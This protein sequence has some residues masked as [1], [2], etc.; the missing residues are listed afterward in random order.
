MSEQLRLDDA[1]LPDYLRRLGLVAAGTPVEVEAAGDGNI[2]WVRRA[3]CPGHSWIVKQA[4]PALERF[5]EYRVPTERIVFEARY[6]EAVRAVDDGCVCP[7]VLHFDARERVLI[8]EDLSGSERLDAALVRGFDASGAAARLGRFLGRVHA[9][10]DRG[11]L[12]P[13][14]ENDA[15][16]RLHGDHI[17]ELPLRKNDFPLSPRLRAAAD[18]LA[19]DRALI[20]L[21][22]AA[23]ARYLEPRG[24]L[25]HGDV[26]AGNVLLAA[27]GAKLLDA[28]IA[29]IGDPCFDVGTLVAHLLLPAAAAG[30]A[31]PAVRY[32][33]A[34]WSA[35]ATT[36]TRLARGA[37]R[38]VARYAGLEMLRRT[39]GAARVPAVE[40]D[41]AG[42]A[43][44]ETALHLI[45]TPPESPDG[46]AV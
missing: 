40:R 32:A 33:E 12:A 2:N 45:R 9:A 46:I 36:R 44:L 25:V 24:A 6:Y 19:A 4:R 41:E 3:A 23:Y 39:I 37:F 1:R 5:P 27:S 30:S 18:R 31:A 26:Q 21:S 16:R 29:H 8:L 11:S 20:R 7:A 13:R 15:M 35:Y 10:T 38:T 14:F 17:F 34:A 42:L 22:D 43:V 28:E